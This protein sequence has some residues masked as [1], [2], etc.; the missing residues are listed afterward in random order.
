MTQKY[1]DAFII[2]Y[3]NN[4]NNRIRIVIN[5]YTKGNKTI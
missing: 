2:K 5:I 4:L 3:Q 1:V